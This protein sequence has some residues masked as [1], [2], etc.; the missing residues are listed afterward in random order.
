M[1]KTEKKSTLIFT[2]KFDTGDTVFPIERGLGASHACAKCGAYY[3]DPCSTWIVA[4][5]MKIVWLEINKHADYLYPTRYSN[6]RVD[7]VYR[8]YSETDLFA[9]KEEAQAEC[10]RRSELGD[11][12]IHPDSKE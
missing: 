7:S 3:T 11:K 1:A 9:T 12:F 2:P 4:E 10:D 8:G 6:N 5:P